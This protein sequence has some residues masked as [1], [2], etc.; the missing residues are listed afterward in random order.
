[1]FTPEEIEELKTGR[2][3]NPFLNQLVDELGFKKELDGYYKKN[4]DCQLKINFSENIRDK[5]DI[6]L[7]KDGNT[8][9]YSPPR[10]VSNDICEGISE[11]ELMEKIKDWYHLVS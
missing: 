8:E 7:L 6:H 1:M 3:N 2:I 9:N 4:G 11:D 10:W 5:F